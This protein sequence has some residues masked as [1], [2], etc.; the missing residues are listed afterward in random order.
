M[1]S[2]PILLI[3]SLVFLLIVAGFGVLK[4]V[5]R[6][7]RKRLFGKLRATQL[8]EEAAM[9]AIYDR[10]KRELVGKWQGGAIL[11]LLKDGRHGLLGSIAAPS[12]SF[13]HTPRMT[14]PVR[15]WCDNNLTSPFEP[16]S[17]M[18]DEER[19]AKI[20]FADPDD[21]FAFKMRWY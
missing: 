8:R 13:I 3:L 11:D 19:I 17:Y 21:A 6:I 20:W 15:R 10:Q 18:N 14:R 2:E 7:H 4:V 16:I 1:F 12:N 5:D 9:Q